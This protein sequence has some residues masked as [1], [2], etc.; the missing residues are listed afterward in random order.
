MFTDV[1][2]VYSVQG[3]NLILLR[4]R[5]ADDY[6]HNLMDDAIRWSVELVFLLAEPSNAF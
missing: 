2:L 3:F 6:V 5:V 4:E 1:Y